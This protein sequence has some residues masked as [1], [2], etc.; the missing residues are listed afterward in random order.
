[1][2]LPYY[3]RY[4]KDFFDATRGW[5]FELRAAYGLVIDLIFVNG[6]ELQDDAGYIA[7]QIGLSVRK[8]NLI[9][10]ELMA[11]GKLIS[12]LSQDNLKIISNKK[13]DQH[14]EKLRKYQDKQRINAVGSNENKNLTEATA[15]ATDST[16]APAKQKPPQERPREDL[17]QKNKEEEDACARDGEIDFQK[18]GESAATSR[19]SVDAGLLD[20]VRSAAGVQ[21]HEMGPYWSD[22]SLTAHIEAWRGFGLTD[23]QITAEV[24]SSRAKNPEAPNGP[25]A[26]DGWMRSAARGAASNPKGPKRAE[27]KPPS[28]MQDRMAFYADW[29]NGSKPLPP[30][31]ISNTMAFAL[32]ESNLVTKARLRERGIAA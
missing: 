23:D 13:A 16:N 8:W 22:S 19:Q 25:K 17:R 11:R 29:V 1:M 27:S 2:T 12:R 5:P 26:L 21:V 14:V 6:G 28:T 3:P 31:A 32:L 9:R 15:Q 4:A 10:A 30:S 18:E 20:D 24:L 7:G